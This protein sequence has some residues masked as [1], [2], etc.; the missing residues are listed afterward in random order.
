MKIVKDYFDFK[1]S[2]YRIEGAYTVSLV[3][4]F[5]KKQQA[6]EFA[7]QLEQIKKQLK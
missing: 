7:K 3:G 2:K 4:T 5:G 1:D 6:E